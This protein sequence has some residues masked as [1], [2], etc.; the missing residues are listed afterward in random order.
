MRI[1]KRLLIL[2]FV[3]SLC[4]IVWYRS[5]IFPVHSHTPSF[6][7]FGNTEREENEFHEESQVKALEEMHAIKIYEA[8]WAVVR[9]DAAKML[10][11]KDEKM[12]NKAE[13]LVIS[14]KRQEEKSKR[15][16]KANDNKNAHVISPPNKTHT[17]DIIDTNRMARTAEKRILDVFKKKKSGKEIP[18]SLFVLVP[19]APAVVST[20]PSAIV[21][22]EEVGFAHA[23]LNLTGV[24]LQWD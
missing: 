16:N 22:A 11:E 1:Y 14:L 9:K 23:T 7:D 8:E 10:A 13:K 19:T 3:F 12:R 5:V 2:V 17:N 21:S 4:F 24:E 15:Q 20:I 18:V 6:G